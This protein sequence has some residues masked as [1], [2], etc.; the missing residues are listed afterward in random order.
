MWK[1]QNW[2][3]KIEITKKS[4]HEV[5]TE[6]YVSVCDLQFWSK[7]HNSKLLKEERNRKISSEIRAGVSTKLKGK[8]AKRT[9]IVTPK[10]EL[11]L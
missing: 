7:N 3:L 1:T 9:H 4:S 5:Q 2:T 6:A 10:F 8:K 11:I